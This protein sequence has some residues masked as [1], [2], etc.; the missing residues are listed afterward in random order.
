MCLL[1][2]PFFFFAASLNLNAKLGCTPPVLGEGLGVEDGRIPDSSLT[3][4]SIWGFGHEAYRGRLNEVAVAGFNVGAWVAGLNDNN[5]WVKVICS[6]MSKCALRWFELK[7]TH[8][9]K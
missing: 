2:P 4:S 5:K 8:I 9:K 6:S 3:S 1:P 7:C